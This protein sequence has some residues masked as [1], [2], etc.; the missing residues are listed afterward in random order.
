MVLFLDVAILKF[1][2]YQQMEEKPQNKLG[3]LSH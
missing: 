3:L 2:M 1:K